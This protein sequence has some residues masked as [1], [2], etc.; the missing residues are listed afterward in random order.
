[1]YIHI[2]GPGVSVRSDTWRVT[3]SHTLLRQPNKCE[4]CVNIDVNRRILP[5]HYEAPLSAR[6]IDGKSRHIICVPGS[7]TCES[8]MRSSDP[9]EMS[10][11]EFPTATHTI[12]PIEKD[13]S[14][15]V[16]TSLL[17][18]NS[19]TYRLLLSTHNNMQDTI[20]ALIKFPI[21]WHEHHFRRI[22]AIEYL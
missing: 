6:I 1:M 11:I 7:F 5:E 9:F 2:H 10:F 3:S 14:L 15:S 12:S 22:I 20:P 8:N 18:S 17:S 21:I 19:S 13:K 4:Y 16:N